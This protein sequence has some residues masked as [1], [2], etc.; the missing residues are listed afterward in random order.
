MIDR[1][2]ARRP[3]AVRLRDALDAPK[4][5]AFA[6]A[7]LIVVALGARI[8]LARHVA[9]PWVMPD[10]LEYSELAKSFEAGG[11]YLFRDHPFALKTIYP[12]LISPAWIAN[13][14]STTYETAKA[15]NVVIMISYGWLMKR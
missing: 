13:S 10:E 6:V 11:Q 5:I 2:L 12:A 3:T 1:A 9:A 7:G 8:L 14:M 15:M 4:A